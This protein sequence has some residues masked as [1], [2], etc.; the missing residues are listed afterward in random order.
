MN[1]H[2][3]NSVN[4]QQNKVMSECVDLDVCYLA[5]MVNY[6]KLQWRVVTDGK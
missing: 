6:G 2:R 4:I 1:I 5:L 3:R